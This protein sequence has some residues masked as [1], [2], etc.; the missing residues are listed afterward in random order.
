MSKANRHAQSRDLL[1]ACSSRG[2]TF[3]T[4]P[5]SYPIGARPGGSGGGCPNGAVPGESSATVVAG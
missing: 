4:K 2:L 3:W 1:F 5:E